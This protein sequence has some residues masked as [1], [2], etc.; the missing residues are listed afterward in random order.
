MK[1]GPAPKKNT[2]SLSGN[3]V[4]PPNAAGRPT[5]SAVNRTTPVDTTV[6]MPD[7][8]AGYVAVDSML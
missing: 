7:S 8:S 5:S 3:T 6:T 1:Q 2:T 4:V